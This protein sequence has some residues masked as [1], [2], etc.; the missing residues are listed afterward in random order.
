MI[1]KSNK[2]SCY[3]RGYEAGFFRFLNNCY[4]IISNPYYF[5]NKWLLNTARCEQPFCNFIDLNEIT[6]Q[7]SN[8]SCES[9]AANI[10]YIV[11]KEIK[12]GMLFGGGAA[13]NLTFGKGSALLAFILDLE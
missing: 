2:V 3:K 13:M 8:S 9:S 5:N 4:Q 7:N 6:N 12:S 11:I 1:R 10:Y